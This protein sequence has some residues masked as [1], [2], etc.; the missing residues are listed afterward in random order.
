MIQYLKKERWGIAFFFT[1][2]VILFISSYLLIGR[3]ATI[4]GVRVIFSLVQY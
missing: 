2:Y 3:P 1:S 4:E